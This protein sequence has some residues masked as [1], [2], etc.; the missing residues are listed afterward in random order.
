MNQ[1]R[2]LY[3]QYVIHQS[4]RSDQFCLEAHITSDVSGTR[5]KNIQHV[6][7][8]YSS[9]GPD[10]VQRTGAWQMI[11]KKVKARLW[12]KRLR[13]SNA[14][15]KISKTD[16]RCLEV[17]TCEVMA[18]LLRRLGQE[19]KTADERNKGTSPNLVLLQLWHRS[20]GD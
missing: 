19:K 6:S 8:L 2:R 5:S 12:R 14:V 11:W 9:Q 20:F 17:A 7:I 16:L 15:D 10:S 1:W 3:T 13:G 18:S 4:D